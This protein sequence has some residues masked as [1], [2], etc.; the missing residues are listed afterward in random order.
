MQNFA[1]SFARNLGALTSRQQVELQQKRVAVIGC[2]G[3]GGYVIEE[4]A[5]VGIGHL[6]LFDPDVFS[7][8]NCNRQLNALGTTLGQNKAAVAAARC[9]T[10]HPWCTVQFF[11]TDFRTV[12]E[13]EGFAVDIAVDCLDDIAARRDL[14]AL[15][16]RRHLPLVHGAVNGWHGQVG[17]QLPGDDLIARLY[18][19]RGPIQPAPPPPVLSF[20]VALVASLQAAEVVKSVLGLRSPLEHGWMHIDLKEGEFLING[21]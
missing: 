14:S 13:Q 6:V 8:S 18:P 7:P 12:P 21:V 2:G 10:I 20:T 16:T 5:R 19:R 11:A 3:L 17:V 4:L 1:D 9:R 15:C